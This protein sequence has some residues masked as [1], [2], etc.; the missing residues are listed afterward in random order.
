MEFIRE[1]DSNVDASVVKSIY[2][3]GNKIAIAFNTEEVVSDIDTLAAD[4]SGFNIKDFSNGKVN[5]V[6]GI[7]INEKGDIVILDKGPLVVIS[8]VTI[9]NKECLAFIKPFTGE[10]QDVEF[11]I[12]LY[13]HGKIA[14]KV[15]EVSV[16]GGNDTNITSI[17]RKDLGLSELNKLAS[18][19]NT[20][21]VCHP[22]VLRS[23]VKV[24]KFKVDCNKDKDPSTSYTLSYEDSN[25]DEVVVM[26]SNESCIHGFLEGVSFAR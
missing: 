5:C 22:L 16:N 4:N 6:K 7:T 9:D 15:V 17:K 24:K 26:V 1:L 8:R 25:G 23:E 20:S 2:E 21:L 19:L 11:S 10:L 13:D 3:R 12:N 18:M 14:D